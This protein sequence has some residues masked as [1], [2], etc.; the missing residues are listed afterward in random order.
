MLGGGR[1][2]QVGLDH[3]MTGQSPQNLEGPQGGIQ[4][5]AGTASTLTVLSFPTHKLA[6]SQPG[7]PDPTATQRLQH[8]AIW[9]LMSH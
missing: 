2:H 6:S 4:G 1:N 5:R 8:P 7:N 9:L 3:R